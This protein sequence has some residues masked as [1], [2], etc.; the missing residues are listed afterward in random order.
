MEQNL[1]PR[2]DDP[3]TAATVETD[4]AVDD[5][6]AEFAESTPEEV[7]AL[8]DGSTESTA[9]DRSVEWLAFEIP[10][11]VQTADSASDNVVDGPS[12]DELF[13]EH[14]R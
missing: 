4:A 12:M 2:S 14:Q 8:D 10:E 6:F 5:V 1:S 7:M 9:P 3:F 13:G 11:R